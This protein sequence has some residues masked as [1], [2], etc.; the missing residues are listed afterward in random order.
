MGKLYFAKLNINSNINEISEEEI[1]V[2]LKNLYNAIDDKKDYIKEVPVKYNDENGEVQ[3]TFR[4]EK[5]NFSQI[6]K[7]ESNMVITGWLVRRMP[8]FIEEFDNEE[9]VSSPIVYD[10]TS[11]STM[12]Y[13]NL[14]NEIITFTTKGRLGYLQITEAL[15]QLFGIY[16]EDIGFKII[17]KKNPFGIDETLKK[18]KKVNKIT[19]TLIPP[20]AANREAL[21]KLFEEKAEELKAINVTTEKIIWETDKKNKS[22]INKKSKRFK[23]LINLIKAFAE[24]GYGNTE[25]E[26]ENSRGNLIE[27][28]SDKDSAYVEIIADENK[29]DRSTVIAVSNEGIEK[30]A[31][32]KSLVDQK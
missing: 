18:M 27:F 11:A 20:N 8:T 32:N 17:L 10:N 21:E 5:Y 3:Y 30:L 12:V 4:E 13:M 15:E 29:E 9:R 28:D 7:D 26:G 1:K 31:V 14:E 22:G 25:I 19:T 16:V 24:R 6:E 2:I 23:K